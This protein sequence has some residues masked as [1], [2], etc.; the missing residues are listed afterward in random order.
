MSAEA[1]LE[2]AD[3]DVA[4]GGQRRGRQRQVCFGLDDV[5]RGA[6]GV[7][8]NGFRL[9][10]DSVAVWVVGDEQ[11]AADEAV[12]VRRA[13]ERAGQHAAG[14][15]RLLGKGDQHVD[16]GWR[17]QLVA[18]MMGW[19]SISAL[20]CRPSSSLSALS[21]ASRSIFTATIRLSAAHRADAWPWGGW[22]TMLPAH[23][24]IDDL[25]WKDCD[26]TGS[27]HVQAIARCTARRR[28][29]TPRSR[30]PV[31]RSRARRC[32]PLAG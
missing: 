5:E 29:A 4:A 21:T 24:V 23:A 28:P 15:K 22:M 13:D 26:A 25:R 30:P 14:F 7:W 32:R 6:D 10:G 2:A 20:T 11:E 1:V 8:G 17:P 31:R 18:D 16:P 27:Q 3:T 12:D 9:G 19:K